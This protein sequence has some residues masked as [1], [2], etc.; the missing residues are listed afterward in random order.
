[1]LPAGAVQLILIC[2]VVLPVVEALR[3]VGALG[4]DDSVADAKVIE[5]SPLTVEFTR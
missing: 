4:N 2:E 1:M 5:S 3:A